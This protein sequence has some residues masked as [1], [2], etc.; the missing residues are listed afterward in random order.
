M[1]NLLFAT[2]L[3]CGFYLFLPSCSKSSAKPPVTSDSTTRTQPDSNGTVPADSV[4]AK[5]TVVEDTVANT[6]SYFFDQGGF[7]Y[8]PNSGNY[9][10]GANDYLTLQTGG[11][12]TGSENGIAGAG[13]YQL[14]Q[15][16]G[17]SISSRPALTKAKITALTATTLTISGS[18]MSSNGGVLTETLYL[19]K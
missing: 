11:T 17:I 12:Y 1:K 4:I 5:W 16:R 6:N 14:L 19:K 8:Y 3:L 15:A 2:L 7:P 13:T 10:G 18:D 9:T